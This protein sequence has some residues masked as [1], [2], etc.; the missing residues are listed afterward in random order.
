MDDR[1]KLHINVSK[2]TYDKLRKIA[3]K[4]DRSIHYIVVKMIEKGIRKATD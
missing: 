2:E 1:I 3:D 4:E